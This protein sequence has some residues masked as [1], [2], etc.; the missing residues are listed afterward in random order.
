MQ[1]KEQIKVILPEDVEEKIRYLCRTISKVEW[2]G[3]L[4]YTVE[5][6]IK[7]P[8]DMVITLKEIIVMD[9]GSSARTEYSF[10]EKARDNSGYLD[11]HIDYTNENEEA[12]FW[13]IGQIHSHH[14]MDVFF[15]GV[16]L[17]ELNDNS[18][19]HNYYLSMIVNN[20]MDM[21]AKVAF[22]AK[23]DTIVEANYTAIDD[24]GEPYVITPSKFTVKKEKLY[25]YNCD[26]VT[27]VQPI[28]VPEYF[29]N[30]VQDVIKISEI[31]SRPKPQPQKPKPQIYNYPNQVPISKTS[32]KNV[33][34]P[35]ISKDQAQ[36]ENSFKP[37]PTDVARNIFDDGD[38]LND[39]FLNDMEEADFIEQFIMATFSGGKLPEKHKNLD[40]LLSELELFIGD[41]GIDANSVS[42]TFMEMY[43]PTFQS[44]FEEHGEEEGEFESITQIVIEI[45]E[46]HEGIFKFLSKT[47]MS[48]KYMLNK[49]ENYGKSTIQ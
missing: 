5:G 26:I 25:D 48:I 12:I 13:K 28:S 20:S 41:D 35:N 29:I 10:N 1:L 14:N 47:I 38:L 30:N 19:S 33:I 9:K 49:F 39:T 37:L 43:V 2:S 27:N 46:E 31:N 8:K 21:I 16:D 15:S 24:N 42:A 45:L 4:L 40:S 3:I 17:A 22:R 44:F 11:R 36:R 7:Q 34:N 6:S 23:V 32:A 18:E